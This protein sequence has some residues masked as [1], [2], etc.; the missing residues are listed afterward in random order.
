M[1]APRPTGIFCKKLFGDEDIFGRRTVGR[2]ICRRSISGIRSS[3]SVLSVDHGC[4]FQ[5]RRAG[6]SSQHFGLNK[7]GR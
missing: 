6:L 5:H 2:T 3:T 1:C 7:N 4:S